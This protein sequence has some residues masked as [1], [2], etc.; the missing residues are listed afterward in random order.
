ML[1]Q[2]PI[3]IKLIIICLLF[4]IDCSFSYGQV[5]LLP[6]PKI[7]VDSNKYDFGKVEEGVELKHVFK[8]SNTGS[9][10]LELWHVTSTC[11][12]TVPT[13]EKK[14]LQ[15]GESTKL[16]V[17]V[18][19]AL[20]QSKITKQV[21]LTSS[22]PIN[23]VTDF[24][25]SMDVRN[26]HIRM[27]DKERAKI[28]TSDHCTSCH[29]AM[30]AGTFGMELYQSDCAMCHGKRAQGVV[31]PPLIGPYENAI[32]KEN[33][34]QI[35]SYGSKSHRSMPGFLVDAGGPLSKEQIDSI[36]QYLDELSK[37]RRK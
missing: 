29:V 17:I 22:D 16:T 21:S 2:A 33:I 25:L 37:A 1:K 9:K 10:V 19:T 5:K 34:K 14:L 24:Y 13:L 28:F 32:F 15:P 4:L 11:G 31:G 36:V 30:G 12:C 20:K 6:A 8:V 18:D 35:T 23:R 26:P 27:S 7:S 3:A